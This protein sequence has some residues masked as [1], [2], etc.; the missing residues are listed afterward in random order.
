MKKVICIKT[1]TSTNGKSTVYKDSIY[2]VVRL[3]R[4]EDGEDMYVLQELP[5]CIA[6][7]SL[8]RDYEE[9]P[10]LVTFTKIVET[11]PIHAN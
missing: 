3:C 8:F 11:Y 2:H 6:A 5:N 9:P 4:D 10:V 7:I 1:R